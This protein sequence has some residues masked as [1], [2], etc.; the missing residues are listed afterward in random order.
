MLL[1]V[2]GYIAE[3]NFRVEFPCGVRN[4]LIFIACVGI[5][6]YGDDRLW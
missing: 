6:G 2:H 3:Y 4:E 1:E 5:I